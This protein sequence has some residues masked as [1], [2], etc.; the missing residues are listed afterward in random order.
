MKQNFENYEKFLESIDSDINK[1]FE[2]QKEYIHCRKGCSLCCERGDYPVSE[3]EFNYLK[4]EA[5]KQS[6]QIK[7]EIKYKAGQIK[8][9]DMN[10]YI[11]PFLFDRRC[12][13][14]NSRPLVCRLFGVLTEDK[15]GNP[16][17]PFCAEEK[18]NF[19]EVYDEKTKHLSLDLAIKKNLKIL[20]KFFRLSNQVVLNLPLAKK[21]N[22]EFGETKK[23]IDF[24]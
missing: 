20:P 3:L 15:S 23:L 22:L 2:Y 13:I 11:C 19:S 12:I 24:L 14:Y 17:Y 18:L 5:D 16:V 21:L 7:Q 8:K 9:G 10:S 6:R 4:R 1:I